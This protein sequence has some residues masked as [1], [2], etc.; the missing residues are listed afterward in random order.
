MTDRFEWSPEKTPPTGVH[1][2]GSCGRPLELRTPDGDEHLRKICPGC[3]RIHYENPLVCV[4]CIAYSASGSV[5]LPLTYLDRGEKI[6]AAA[7]RVL[8]ENGIAGIA[9]EELSLFAA[10][11]DEGASKLFLIFRACLESHPGTESAKPQ[12]PP[13]WVGRLLERFESDLRRGRF[14]V[15]TGRVAGQSLE[16]RAVVADQAGTA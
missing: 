11:T 9:E 3:G 14:E 6:Q 8:G 16:L 1:Y 15:Y 7:L 2:C 4:G 12:G 10:I 13:A 5:G